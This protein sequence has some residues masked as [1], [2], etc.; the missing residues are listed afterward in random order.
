MMTINSPHE[1]RSTP[2]IFVI[3]QIAALWIASDLGY[4]ILF[5][6]GYD[7]E[8]VR[9]TLY[10]VFW[11]VLTAFS[12]RSVYYAWKPMVNR[13]LAYTVLCAGSAGI[14][15][16]ITYILPHFPAIVWTKFWRFTN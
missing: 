13:L 3:P 7:T 10:Y 11:L 14:V 4:Y 16:Y 1:I 6:G 9:I 12:F 8:P 2:S 15:L 5:S